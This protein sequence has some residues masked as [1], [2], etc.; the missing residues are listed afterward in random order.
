[1]RITVRIMMLIEMSSG[2]HQDA[3]GDVIR[4]VIRMSYQDVMTMHVG[5]RTE[6]KSIT[7]PSMTG[8]AMPRL[9]SRER[10]KPRKLSS[11]CTI[12]CAHVA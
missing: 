4:K 9:K 3:Y 10:T 12:A 5:M 11:K 2:C 1:M 8:I 7:L 6:T